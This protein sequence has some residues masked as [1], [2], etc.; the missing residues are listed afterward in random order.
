MEMKKLL[1]VVSCVTLLGIGMAAPVKAGPILPKGPA[2]D[3][4]SFTN[5]GNVKHSGGN[6]NFTPGYGNAFSV[7]NA[8]IY[9]LRAQWGNIGP[10]KTGLYSVTNGLLNLKTGGCIEFCT[11]INKNGFQ[12][13]DFSGTGSSLKLTGEI[14][15]LGIT[16][17]STILISGYFSDLGKGANPT[18]VSLNK[19]TSKKNPGG[20]GMTG[21]L[22]ITSI[23][24]E[25]VAALGLND[26]SG[27]GQIS[28]MLF[29]LNYFTNTANWN[30]AV[31]SS[32]IVVIPT[33]E[34]TNLLL[35]GSALLAAAWM[36]RRRVRA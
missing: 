30:G 1:M 8:P 18:N 17:P 36:T 7:T 4:S 24:P 12:G 27:L 26:Q 31:G 9:Q 11:G 6:V 28:E 34:P 15:A 22:V 32:D 33:P 20:G 19:G 29:N 14:A 10:S 23:N 13:V 21:Y 35:L 2:I 25:L 5:P 16:D 3:F